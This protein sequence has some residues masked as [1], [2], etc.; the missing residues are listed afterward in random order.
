MEEEES[1]EGYKRDELAGIEELRLRMRAKLPP[2]GAE[3]GDEGGYVATPAT[4][5]TAMAAMDVQGSQ[6]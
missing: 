1:E 6:G 2:P 3:M 5:S 4:P